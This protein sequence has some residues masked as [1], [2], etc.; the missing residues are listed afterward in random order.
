VI[1][2]NVKDVLKAVDR[3]AEEVAEEGAGLVLKDAKRL[4][5]SRAKSPTGELAS[6]IDVRKS[7]FKDGGFLVMSQGPGTWKPP[8]RATFV[9]LGTHKMDAIPHLRP[10]LRKNKTKIHQ[11]YKD[12]L[13]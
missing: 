5:M 12:R 1:V 6:Q 13:K 2:W 3:I 7:K 10:A 8:Y 4:L 11:L 9:E